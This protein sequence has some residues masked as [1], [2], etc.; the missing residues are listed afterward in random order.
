MKKLISI[1][2][3][4][5][6][7]FLLAGCFGEK[8]TN[9]VVALNVPVKDGADKQVS[10]ELDRD[11]AWAFTRMYEE[12]TK[13]EFLKTKKAEFEAE[14]A[15]APQIV[16][17]SK[18][19]MQMWGMVQMNKSMG[20]ALVAMSGKGN[21]TYGVVLA[22]SSQPGD[23]WAE[24]IN[25]A[26]SLVGTAATSP[27]GM[28]AATS[29]GI[30]SALK[31]GGSGRNT[32]NTYSASDEASLSVSDANNTKVVTQAAGGDATASMNNGSGSGDGV[33]SEDKES[34]DEWPD[35][36]HE[37]FATCKAQHDPGARMGPVAGCMANMGIDVEIVH[38]EFLVNGKV[39]PPGMALL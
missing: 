1:L 24:R 2:A 21:D 10:V 19:E 37:A 3:V 26:G 31:H 35:E 29:Y 4:V 22:T 6:S 32:T 39:Y 15:A 27:A 5:M 14:K 7:C 18:D 34:L 23:V 33:S 13:Q 11:G 20:D 12:E 17:D 8:K 16:I 28:I 9:S 38:G 30:T 25:A 36:V